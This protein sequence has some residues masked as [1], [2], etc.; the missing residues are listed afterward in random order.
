M[1][2]ND[3]T[4]SSRTK[5]LVLIAAACA[6][7]A[8][9]AAEWSV[10]P[11]VALSTSYDDNIR[12]FAENNPAI[13][14]N[15]GV[16]VSPGVLFGLETEVRKVSGKVRVASRRYNKDTDLNANDVLFDFDWK[17]KGERSEFGLTSNNSL[18]S[19][20]ATLL[21]Q[22]GLPLERKQRQRIS[23]FPSYTYNL[24]E[25][26]ALSIGYRFEDVGF[27]DAQKTALLDYRNNEIIPAWRYR[28]AQNDEIELNARLGSLKTL[29]NSLVVPRTKFKNSAINGLYSHPVDETLSWSVGLGVFNVDA[30]AS[31][32]QPI[33]PPALP[34][35]ART[36][37]QSGVQGGFKVLQRYLSG[38]IGFNAGR[39]INAAGV[40]ALV[41]TRRAVVEWNQNLTEL[42]RFAL[43]TAYYD[44]TTIG[45]A[46]ADKIRY[47]R[48]EPRLTWVPSREWSLD[49][50]LSYRNARQPVN[51]GGDDRKL[52]SKG[53][54]I[55]FIYTWNK[56][57]ISR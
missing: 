12:F 15:F 11:S 28:T 53:A 48:I 43:T 23:A 39:E 46:E 17:E 21:E 6:S 13:R 30:D 50:G 1:S 34:T 29:P 26:T 35:P 52:T 14:S 8:S 25:R 33:P 31:E 36:T 49:G 38:N 51:N 27:K 55:N 47:F 5:R 16:T 56:T 18:D 24:D 41:D 4:N 9:H 22:T 45:G 40:N 7:L 2:N 37:K 20:L 32:S 57:A 19:T 44:N 3:C 54:F 42:S 10:E